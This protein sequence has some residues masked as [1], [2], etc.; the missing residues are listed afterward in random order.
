[1]ENL[2][3]ETVPIQPDT[4][5]ELIQTMVSQI[6]WNGIT[7]QDILYISQKKTEFGESFNKMIRNFT[8]VKI[9]K[10]GTLSKYNGQ[11]LNIKTIRRMAET[12]FP[13]SSWH[14]EYI[15]PLE[16]LLETIGKKFQ[17]RQE[18]ELFLM[19]VKGKNQFGFL[20]NK[21]RF[22]GYS[23]ASAEYFYCFINQI[24]PL[25]LKSRG[26]WG[27]IICV[28]PLRSPILIELENANELYSLSPCENVMISCDVINKCSSITIMPEY[29]DENHY[30]LLR[31]KI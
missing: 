7:P 28:D 29:F 27:K 1:M 24:N 11:D 10:I 4:V 17:K 9:F 3:N 8:D 5:G 14:G 23:F 12:S 13:L 26:I 16:K 20:K 15:E 2:K 31:K 21:V 22:Y 30:I 18:S 6:K 19:N 25:A